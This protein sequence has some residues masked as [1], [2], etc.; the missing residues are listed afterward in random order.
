VRTESPDEDDVSAASDPGMEGDPAGVAAHDLDDH[1][2]TVRFSGRVQPVDRFG[3]EADRGVEPETARRSE[4]VVVD[5]L[6][7][8]DEWDAFLVELVRNRERPIAADAHERVEAVLLEHVHDAVRVIEGALRRDDRFDEGVAAVDGAE[9]RAAEPED[10]GHIAWNEHARFLGI[11]EAIEAVF[12]PQDLDARVV[13]G[14]DHCA[15][16]RVETGGVTPS[17]QYTKLLDGHEVASVECA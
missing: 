1:D 15:D 5:G 17:R 2:A 11:D 9:N 14:F 4:D 3:R 13:T 8:A 12:D 10:P 16:H 6:R 7:N